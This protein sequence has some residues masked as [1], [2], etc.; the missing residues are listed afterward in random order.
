MK[1][2]RKS[3]HEVFS[4][5]RYADTVGVAR[6]VIACVAALTDVSPKDLPP[7]TDS[8]DPDALD[9]LIVSATGEDCVIVFLFAGTR[10]SVSG[11]GDVS[12]SLTQYSE[13]DF[14]A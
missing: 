10:V 7:L 2:E 9:A 8:V 1:I 6:R 12:V 4:P 11:N 3:S 13:P 14:R 5:G